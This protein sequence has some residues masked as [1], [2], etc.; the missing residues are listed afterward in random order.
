MPRIYQSELKISLKN[1]LTGNVIYESAFVVTR[2]KP[3]V[4]EITRTHSSRQFY[5]DQRYITRT[6]YDISG[7]SK[8]EMCNAEFL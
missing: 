7:K 8:L 4:C 6:I 2:Q 5:V 3:Y 1:S